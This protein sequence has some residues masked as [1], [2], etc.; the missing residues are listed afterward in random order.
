MR[1]RNVAATV[2]AGLA[3][4]VAVPAASHA[5]GDVPQIDIDGSQSGAAA[6]HGQDLANAGAVRWDGN[7]TGS[8][9]VGGED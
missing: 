5:V 8:V 9:S 2:L 1:L 6:I 4:T 7:A 3:L